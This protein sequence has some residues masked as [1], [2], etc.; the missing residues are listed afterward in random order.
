MTRVVLVRCKTGEFVRL[1]AEGHSG[2][3]PK[4]TD[5]V[6]SALTV[7]LRTVMEVLENTEGLD[8]ETEFPSPGI[9]AFQVKG[10]QVGNLEKLRFSA[11]ILSRGLK[12]LQEE[13]PE[14]VQLREIIQDKITG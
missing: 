2:Y 5:I 1:N 10:F 11:E 14:N 6:C 12:D 8:L 7:L 4:G 9:L 3:G 13:F